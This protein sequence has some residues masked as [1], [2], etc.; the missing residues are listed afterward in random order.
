MNIDPV[1]A[2]FVITAIVAVPVYFKMRSE[3]RKGNGDAYESLAT[4]LRTSGQTIDDLFK[5][6]AEVPE[7]KR[8][9][10]DMQDE[11]DDLRLGVGILTTQLLKRN[12]APE[13]HPQAVKRER[14][15]PAK[16]SSGFSGR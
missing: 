5:M 9:L 8:Q 14:T 4:A 2:Q 16:K 11:L 6:L 1:L 7:L 10:D 3:W 15:K 12:I 13:W